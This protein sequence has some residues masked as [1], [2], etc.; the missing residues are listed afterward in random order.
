LTELQADDSP[1]IAC[2]LDAGQLGDREAEWRA[3]LGTALV[4]R[5]RIPSGIRVTVRPDAAEELNRLVDLERGCCAW[6]RFEFDAPES[7]SITAGGEGPE[8]LAAMFLDS[9]HPA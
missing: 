9:D 3:L 1:P 4:A 8:V 7:V 6:M 5:A 2:S